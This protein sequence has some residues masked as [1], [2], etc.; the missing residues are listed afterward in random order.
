MKK[1]TFLLLTVLLFGSCRDKIYQKH[2][3]Y[4]PVYQDFSTF[5]NDIT[6]ENPR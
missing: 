2:L 6:F 1:I 4:V 3:A 5:L